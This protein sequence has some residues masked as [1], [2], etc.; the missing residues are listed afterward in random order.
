MGVSEFEFEC[1]QRF[2]FS[3]W[4]R[5]HLNLAECFMYLGVSANTTSML[6]SPIQ[7]IVKGK[8]MSRITSRYPYSRTTGASTLQHPTYLLLVVIIVRPY[9]A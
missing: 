1:N 8:I 3:F 5:E 6:L 4:N 9:H 2:S 7:H